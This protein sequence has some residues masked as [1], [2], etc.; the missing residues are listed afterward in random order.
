M[1]EDKLAKV[2]EYV[3][4]T[5]EVGQ[6]H[7]ALV[8]AVHGPFCINCL[9]VSDSEDK[10]DQYGRQIERPS[11]VQKASDN[12][13]HGRVFRFPYEEKKPYKAPVAV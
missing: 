11:S 6:D 13:A 12:T 1:A 3:I 9:Y 2:G 5:D 8:T 7:D 4:Y 10:R